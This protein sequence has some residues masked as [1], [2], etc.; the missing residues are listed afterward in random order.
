MNHLSLCTGIGGIDLAAEWAG[1]KTVAFCEIADYPSSVFESKYPSVKRIKDIRNVSRE[2]VRDPIKLVSSGFP[3]QPYSV[4]GERKGEADDRFLWPENIR[5][6]SEFGADWFLGENVVGFADLGLDQA[7]SDLEAIGYTARPFNIP[8]C[9][10]GSPD[11]RA[12]LFIV[13]HA[14]SKRLP[15]GQEQGSCSESWTPSDEQLAGLL[16]SDFWAEVPMPAINRVGYGIPNRVERTKALGNA[17]KPQQVYPILKA[18]ALIES[19]LTK[20]VT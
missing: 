16:P 12:R 13:A 10:L 9:A 1:F 8:A 5:I 18:I 17:V 4:A 11:S 20:E 6:L 15:R 3:C 14:N 2:T 7:L 19:H